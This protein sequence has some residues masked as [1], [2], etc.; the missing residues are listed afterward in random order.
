MVEPIDLM[1]RKSLVAAC[2]GIG[3]PAES[4]TAASIEEL[5]ELLKAGPVEVW[6]APE[7]KRRVVKAAFLRGLS[8]AAR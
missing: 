7:R 6:P 1:S 4:L 2:V 3:H 5:R 8:F